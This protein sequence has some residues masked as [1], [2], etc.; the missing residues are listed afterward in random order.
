MLRGLLGFARFWLDFIVGDDWRIAA[1]V[2]LG[3]LGGAWLVHEQIVRTDIVAIGFGVAVV[4]LA[5]ASI[6]ID[7]RRMLSRRLPR[8]TRP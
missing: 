6:L 1:G 2:V 7:A 3:I 4:L 8:G 5:A